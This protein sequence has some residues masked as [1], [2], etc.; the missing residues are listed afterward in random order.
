MTM[1]PSSPTVSAD[2]PAVSPPQ[3]P[4]PWVDTPAACHRA[5]VSKRIIYGRF[6]R[7]NCAPP[8]SMAEAITGFASNGLMPGWSR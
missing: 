2:D 8:G 3:S 6:V 4:S 1:V 7:E 5:H